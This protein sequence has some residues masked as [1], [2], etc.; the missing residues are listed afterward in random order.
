VLR[1]HAD[2]RRVETGGRVL[3]LDG[4]DAMEKGALAEVRSRGDATVRLLDQLGLDARTLGNHDFAW[5]LESVQQQIASPS[6]AVLASNIHGE[7]FAAKR[8][9][10]FEVGCVRVGVFGLV[11]NPYDETDERVD[12]PYLG[13]LAQDH[14]PGDADRYVSTAAALVRELRDEK[15]D[16]VIGLNHL[17]IWRDRAIIDAVPGLDLV[18][19]AHD[20]APING[21]VQGKHGA[22]VATGSFLGGRS[23]ARIGETTL[24]IDLKTRAVKVAGAGFSRV[25]ELRD[26][27]APVQAEVERLQQCFAADAEVPIADLDGSLGPYNVDAWT[28]V[29]DAALR[30]RFPE[31]QAF[32]YE[33]S[34]SGGIV[35]GELAKGPV[36]PQM[37]ADFA[38][39][40]R[41]R[42]GGPGFTAF[43]EIVVDAA[44]MRELCAATPRE[45]I[46]R[47]C[48]AELGEQSY[49]V[50]IERRPLYA[51][52]L[53]F[54]S[55]P[56]LWPKPADETAV[57][58][59]DVLMEYARARGKACRALDREVQ[60]VCR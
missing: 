48:P 41:Q 51:P 4:G 44:T 19:S 5:G 29:L 34:T 2:R 20:H 30:A 38:F 47:V 1:A 59:M 8:T 60:S 54:A 13:T 22:L 24:E 17:G 33:Q 10:I 6:H 50:V 35:K 40:E 26:L 56:K 58:V 18:I 27:D 57:E 45:R 32:L 7:G 25:D 31:A 15:V 53:A 39:S 14:D 16:V 3:F 49:R 36:T 21:Y 23:E 46:H 28:S 43:D 52:N 42:V 55:V 12:A 37:L 9:V 11:I